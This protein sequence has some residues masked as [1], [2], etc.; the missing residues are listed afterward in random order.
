M[1]MSSATA[2]SPSPYAAVY[3]GTKGFLEAFVNSLALEARPRKI[4][5]LS[6]Q[7]GLVHTNLIKRGRC[8]KYTLMRVLGFIG[9]TPD[10]VASIALASIGRL[11]SIDSGLFA[12]I[13]RIVSKVAGPE[14]FRVLTWFLVERIFADLPREMETR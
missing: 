2:F 13:S 7:A 8:D 5:V 12:V 11:S 10:T 3:A 6:L 4:D 14:V 1:F 9:Q